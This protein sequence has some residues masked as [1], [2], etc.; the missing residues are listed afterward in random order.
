MLMVSDAEVVVVFSDARLDYQATS[1]SDPGYL[2]PAALPRPRFPQTVSPDSRINLNSWLRITGSIA[3]RELR[4]HATYFQRFVTGC[5]TARHCSNSGRSFYDIGG[6]RRLRLHALTTH[7]CTG[8]SPVT[9]PITSPLSMNGD[10]DRTHPYRGPYYG[11]PTE[12]TLRSRP[13]RPCSACQSSIS[14][15]GTIRS[16]GLFNGPPCPEH[17]YD[18]ATPSPL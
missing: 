11:E 15:T 3:G 8:S 2:E 1:S 10:P 18:Q 5:S 4:D 7:P 6:G 17:C 14:G 12:K 13:K 9:G 16:S